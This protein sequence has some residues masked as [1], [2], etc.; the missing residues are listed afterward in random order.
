M[1]CGSFGTSSSTSCCKQCISKQCFGCEGERDKLCVNQQYF[2]AFNFSR[3]KQLIYTTI[4]AT[5]FNNKQP[6]SDS[7]AED[8]KGVYGWLWRCLPEL[9]LSIA[10]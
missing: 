4:I 8:W 5:T 3:F 2:R 9:Y 6:I 7:S 1:V 10:S